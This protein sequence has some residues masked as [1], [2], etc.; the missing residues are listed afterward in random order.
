MENRRMI[1]N[2]IEQYRSLIRASTD[3]ASQ[4][5]LKEQIE[6][7]VAKLDR[8]KHFEVER[9]ATTWGQGKH[10][11]GNPLTIFSSAVLGP[12]FRRKR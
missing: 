3:Q 10:L 4:D 12:A 7:E 8:L 1:E 5:V 6:A 11:Q 2:R 9:M